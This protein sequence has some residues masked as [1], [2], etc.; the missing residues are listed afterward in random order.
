MAHNGHPGY[1]SAAIYL[2][3]DGVYNCVISN[4]VIYNIK[5]KFAVH[6]RGPNHVVRNNIIDLDGPDVLHADV[7]QH[8][9]ALRR[10]RCFESVS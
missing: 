10:S 4:N 8:C 1:S 2:D 5:Q 7:S 6:V 3:M 9:A